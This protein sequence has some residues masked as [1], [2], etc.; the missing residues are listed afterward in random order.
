[1]KIAKTTATAA[2][3]SALILL[4]GCAGNPETM[5]TDAAPAAAA[6]ATPEHSE[7]EMVDTE[8]EE[9]DADAAATTAGA[10]LDYTDG[11][12]ESTA[13]PKA[14]FFH[15]TWCPN[16]RQLDEELVA[17]GAPDGLT[18][19]KVDYD[20]RTDLRQKYG[21]TLQTTIVFVDDDGNEISSTVLYED[22]SVASLVAAMP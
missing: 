21:V 22:P 11:A 17:E 20:E 10:Y 12:I 6:S 8:S 18:I 7:D 16:C 14:L 13:G 3:L 19:F 15:A 9:S 4:A 5:E 1:M 2:A